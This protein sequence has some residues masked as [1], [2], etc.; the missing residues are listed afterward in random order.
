MPSPRAASHRRER[1]ERVAAEELRRMKR[2]TER[3]RWYCFCSQ[4]LSVVRVVSADA[5]T[6]KTRMSGFHRPCPEAAEAFWGWGCCTIVGTARKL[7]RVF[8]IVA[9][10]LHPNAPCLEGADEG[11][12]RRILLAIAYTP[13]CK[14]TCSTSGTVFSQTERDKWDKPKCHWVSIP[15]QQWEMSVPL[16]GGWCA[17]DGLSQEPCQKRQKGG[18]GCTNTCRRPQLT[19]SW[20]DSHFKTLFR[21]QRDLCLAADAVFIDPWWVS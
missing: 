10:I 3:R 7:G 16:Y 4:P 18:G 19:L 13:P 9:G 1:A 2:C 21:E 6:S 20:R 15:R 8:A 5:A 12:G 17:R 14:A 11:N